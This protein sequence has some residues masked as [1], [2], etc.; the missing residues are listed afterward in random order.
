MAYIIPPISRCMNNI[1]QA[2]LPA[3]A[4]TAADYTEPDPEFI[5]LFVSDN[6]LLRSDLIKICK[7][8]IA[9]DLIAETFNY[10]VGLGGDPSLMESVSKFLN[11]YFKPAIP[12]TSDHLITAS[13]AGF[14]LDAIASY[15][16]EPGDSIL[17][18]GPYSV[19]AYLYCRAGVTMVP[20]YPS[21]LSTSL[22]SETLFPALETA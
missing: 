6:N 9:Q 16:C 17:V 3:A 15:I 7:H 5:N 18:P 8:A 21:A 10:P 13:G 2:L 19:G 4:A 11:K 1:I 20:A 22:T 14:C 12:I